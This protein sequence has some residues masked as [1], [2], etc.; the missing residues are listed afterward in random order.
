MLKTALICG[1][2]TSVAYSA[3]YAMEQD[4]DAGSKQ[5]SS[6][7]SPINKR[8]PSHDINVSPLKVREWLL[9]EELLV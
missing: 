7:P 1:L 2:L 9:G 3:A 6:R 8:R 4:E 5:G